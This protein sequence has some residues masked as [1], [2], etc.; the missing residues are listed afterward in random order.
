MFDVDVSEGSPPLKL[1]MDKGEDPYDA[2]ERFLMRHSLPESYLEQ[3]A[4]FIVENTGGDCTLH[5]SGGSVIG[6]VMTTAWQSCTC[7]SVMHTLSAV[8]ECP[9]EHTL[10]MWMFRQSA[11]YLFCVAGHKIST[12]RHRRGGFQNQHQASFIC[13]R[14]K[15]AF[16]VAISQPM[17]VSDPFT[18]AGAYV[19]SSG[20]PVHVTQSGNPDPFTGGGAYVPDEPGGAS[21]APTAPVPPGLTFTPHQHYQGFEAVPD[22]S[23]VAAKIRELAN[24]V[25]GA[26]ALTSDEV[27]PGGPVDD[28]VT[29]NCHLCSLVNR[30]VWPAKYL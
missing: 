21:P 9:A 7:G 1:P 25:A 20:G 29:V 4:D 18:G 10:I 19:P 27:A 30:L 11:K 2:A 24:A 8:L 12:A 16:C 13:S 17:T 26:N 15:V 5:L 14:D 6:A 28:I 23:K 22:G 3:V